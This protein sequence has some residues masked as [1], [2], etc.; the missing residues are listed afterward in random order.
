MEFYGRNDTHDAY[1]DAFIDYAHIYQRCLYFD[2]AAP[3]D[4]LPRHKLHMKPKFSTSRPVSRIFPTLHFK[5]LLPLILYLTLKSL[6]SIA[7]FQ[8]DVA[9]S[10]LCES[11]A[12]PSPFLLPLGSP[13]SYTHFSPIKPQPLRAL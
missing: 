6:T 2:K 5:F 11:P 4:L 9:L 12:H 13:T 3:I 1:Q 8:L 10:Y 7:N